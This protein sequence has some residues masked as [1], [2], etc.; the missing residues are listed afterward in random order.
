MNNVDVLKLRDHKFY[1]E[2]FTKIKTKENGIQPF[3]LTPAQID[4]F[5]TLNEYRR[6]AICKARQV[7]ISTGVTGYFYVE[8][9]TNPGVTTVLIGYNADMVTELFDKVKTFYD[10]TPPQIRPKVKYDTKTQMSFP[11]M[12][13][14][15]M[16][17]PCTPNVGRGLTINNCLITELPYWDDAEVKYRGL[18]ES[19]PKKGRLVIESSP[20]GVGNLFHRLWITENE[21]IKKEYGWWWEYSAEEMN[22]KRKEMGE[23]WFSQEYNL[24]FLTTGRSVFSRDTINLQRKNVRNIGDINQAIKLDDYEVAEQKVR[25]EDYWRIYRD[26]NEKGIYVVGGDVSEGVK[27]GDYSTATIFDRKTGEEVAMFRAHVPPDIFAV[28]LDKMGKRYN[29]A[30]MVVESNN[31]GLTT[32]TKLRDIMYPSLYFRPAKFETI[33][34]T[35]T[36]R[37]GWRTTS[38]TRPLMI[39]EFNRA[40]RENNLIIRSKETVDEMS[41]FIYDDNGKMTAQQGYFDDLIFSSG[42]SHQGFKVLYSG[43]LSQIHWEKYFPKNYSY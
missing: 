11:K 33:G 34:I 26:P 43:E 5:N 20:A 36:D 1:L 22:I 9:I 27:G 38:V 39:D 32:L 21:F 4:L 8:T 28:E 31:H 30:L 25:Q 40:V 10:T 37:L 13:S 35:L 42:I 6:I 16:V 29:K 7:K 14:K 41:V 3:L 15:I 24:T 17:L 12:N 18:L 2:Q 23:E 19:I